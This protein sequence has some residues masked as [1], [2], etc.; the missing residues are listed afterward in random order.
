MGGKRTPF[1]ERRK[2][3]GLTQESLAECLGVD[4][5]TVQRWE[6]GDNEPD[7]YLRSR[8]ARVLRVSL[9]ELSRLLA[10]A[11]LLLQGS[12]SG[13]NPDESARIAYGMR[14]PLRIDDR[15][16]TAL[17]DVLSAQRHL[18]DALGSAA[19]IAPTMAQLEK[20]EPLLKESRASESVTR[21][22]SSVIAEWYRFAGWLHASLRMDETAARLLYK[23]EM[24]AD[25][26]K[27]PVTAALAISFRG[28]VARQ[29][30]NW[31]G[32]VRASI[33]ARETPG[34]HHTQ[35]TFDALQAAQGYA[36]I[37]EEITRI[38]GIGVVRHREEARRMLGVASLMID[39]M[40]GD[41]ATPPPSVYWYSSTFFRMYSGL[42]YFGLGDME[43]ATESLAAGL[44]SLPEEYKK[45]E[46][47]QEYWDTLKRAKEAS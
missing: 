12:A 26:G 6:R 8:L 44:A 15:T 35:R 46:W 19:L 1:A 10:P 36:G 11:P 9:D 39:D 18:D 42:V 47:A 37:T 43:S 38:D 3:V 14:N 27:D 24:I 45:T 22:L 28:Y 7:L 41:L 32:V 25:D 23:A 34:A 13:V 30:M 4:R 21:H 2:A 31:H 17:S 16:V 20:I 29:R 5:R 33:A 40:S